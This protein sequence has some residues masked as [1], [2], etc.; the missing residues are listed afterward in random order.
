MTSN[1]GFLRDI[2]FNPS[3]SVTYRP[4]PNKQMAEV[5]I[6]N[7]EKTAI[8]YK[9][10][11]TRPGLYKMR[12]VYGVLGP[13][14]KSSVNLFCKGVKD[15]QNA[16]ITDRYTCVLAASPSANV[17][18]ESIWSNHK[19]QQKL[20]QTGKLRKIK[21]MIVYQG[22]NDKEKEKNQTEECDEENEKDRVGKMR[23][24]KK[25]D[26][27][28]EEKAKDTRKKATLVMFTR[29]DGDSASGEDDGP[30]DTAITAPQQQVQWMN[31]LKP[32][33]D[34]GVYQN[35]Q[36]ANNPQPIPG[37][38][39]AIAAA[40]KSK[41]KTNLAPAPA[42][43]RPPPPAQSPAPP[44]P[45]SA[46]ISAATT[47]SAASAA[48]PVAAKSSNASLTKGTGAAPTSVALGVA[49]TADNVPIAAKSSA[50]NA[51]IGVKSSGTSGMQAA[52]EKQASQT[53]QQQPKDP[54]SIF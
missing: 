11:S 31:L 42:A 10:K 40:A 50:T 38:P 36:I 43:P 32:V 19:Y 3:K 23:Q 34:A 24:K 18:P 28:A 4:I 25:A 41:S 51:P 49:G 22:V 13:G 53:N 17:N 29:K 6:T 5:A 8:I 44:A 27:K 20:A 16:P 39:G 46:P 14:D 33:A 26:G 37:H 15:A 45:V 1:E 12:P 35:K 9:W 2:I 7:N 47:S 52:P 21:L 54:K 30:D 48:P